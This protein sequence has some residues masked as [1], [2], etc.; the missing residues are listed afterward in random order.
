MQVSCLK[1]TTENTERDPGNLVRHTDPHFG[2]SLTNRHPPLPPSLRSGSESG[3]RNNGSVPTQELRKSDGYYL[4]DG[5]DRGGRWDLEL[6]EH[7][8]RGAGGDHA[9]HR[10]AD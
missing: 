1:L 3:G 10:Y 7:E 9:R 4:V 2:N 8:D 6:R 5:S